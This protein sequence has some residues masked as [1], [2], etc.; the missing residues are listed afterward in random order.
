MKADI[1]IG[2]DNAHLLVPYEVKSSPSAENEPF[3]TRTYFGWAVSEAIFGQ[4]NQAYANFIQGSIEKDFDNMWNIEHEVSP[5]S[6][7]YL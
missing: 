1:L 6:P 4:S 2:M 7:S 3:A 5:Q